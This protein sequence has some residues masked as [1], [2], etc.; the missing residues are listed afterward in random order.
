VAEFW[1]RILWNAFLFSIGMIG[2]TIWGLVYGVLVVAMAL[3]WMYRKEG[4]IAVKRHFFAW[5]GQ[6]VA[7]AILAWIPFFLGSLASEIYT[8]WEAEHDVT[9]A[10][11]KQLKEKDQTINAHEKKIQE[12]EKQHQALE[13]KLK[14][15]KVIYREKQAPAATDT[16]SRHLTKVQTARLTRMFSELPLGGVSI[17]VKTIADNQEALQYASE[18]NST[19][20][21]GRNIKSVVERGSF[22]K[23]I[24]EGV[25]ICTYSDTDPQV[26]AVAER[27]IREMI[28]LGIAVIF[29]PN[30]SFPKNTVTILVGA[31]AIE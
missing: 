1:V 29:N 10:L 8:R 23:K 19:L 15:P 17:V 30:P 2:Q 11:D 6:V 28:A 13:T 18:I 22:W 16:G 27:I 20:E 12:L 21:N 3:M 24:P 9:L 31:K 25:L 14:E 7:I 5:A 4:W 26:N